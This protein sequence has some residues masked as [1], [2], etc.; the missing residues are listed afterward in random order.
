MATK[1]NA[2]AAPAAATPTEAWNATL[3]LPRQQ[4]TLAT[5]G[6][7]AMFQASNRCAASRKRP[8]TRP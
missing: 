2:Q 6:A 1:R 7:C 4:M 5:E 8:R 3:D